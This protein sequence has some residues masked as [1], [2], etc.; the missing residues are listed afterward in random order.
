M[1]LPWSESTEGREVRAFDSS[2]IDG[3]HSLAQYIALYRRGEVGPLSYE[4]SGVPIVVCR[5]C[6][7]LRPKDGTPCQSCGAY[8]HC[9]PLN[10][11]ADSRI[12][13]AQLADAARDS[14]HKQFN[15]RRGRRSI[16]NG[17][18]R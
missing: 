4:F 11:D 16:R 10:Q 5:M 14:I 13:A 2:P 7:N 12:V 17:S 15:P 18:S 9:T 8:Q 6:G 3:E 1:S